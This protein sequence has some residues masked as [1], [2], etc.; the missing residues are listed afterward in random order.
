MAGRLA[1]GPFFRLALAFFLILGA[2]RAHLRA[3]ALSPASRITL[4]RE[5]M[6]EFGTLRA[7]LPRGEK[8]LRL[9]IDGE[10]DRENLTKEIS[11]NGTALAAST[12]VQITQIE[13]KDKEIVF[14][15]NGGGKKKTKWYE[16]IQVGIGSQTTRI[17]NPNADPTAGQGSSI[18]LLFPEKLPEMTSEDLKNYLLPAL[19]FAVVD[20]LLATSE[21]IPPEFQKAI[22]EKR[23]EVGMSQDM[24]RAALGAP[25]RKVRETQEG[26]ER[27]DWIYGEPPL[28]VVFVTFEGDEVVNVEEHRGG[29]RGESVSYPVEP[30][31]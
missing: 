12:V 16:R 7:P 1:A 29:V 18:T 27:E 20:P 8:G 15:I 9:K 31:R 3:Q 22:E 19:D 25:D 26:V 10:I 6:A 17:N 13:F 14:E 4:L 5:L 24:V 21:P 11:K 2:H 30:P 23:A 28:K